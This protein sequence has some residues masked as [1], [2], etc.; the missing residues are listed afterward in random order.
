MICAS[1]VLGVLAEVGYLST[2][3]QHARGRHALVEARVRK[4]VGLSTPVG[5]S[6]S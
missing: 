4:A 6:I 3:K 1:F 5:L 2:T